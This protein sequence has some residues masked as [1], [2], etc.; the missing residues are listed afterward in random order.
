[1]SVD[2]VTLCAM[3][4]ELP[5]ALRFL[6]GN[7]CGVV[8]RSQALRTGLTTDMIKFRLRSGRW[9]LMHRGVYITF[10]GVPG[11]GARL[12]A[13][14][15]SAGPGAMLS[16][17][18]AAELQELADKATNPIHVTVPHERHV[19]A[20]EGIS[21]H[22]SGRAAEA[23]EQRSY[24]PRTRV[25]ETV[26]DLTQTAKTF[27]DVCGRVTRPLARALTDVA[28]LTPSMTARATLRWRADPYG[29]IAAAAGGDHSVLEL[30]YDRDV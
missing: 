4:S 24:P 13:A 11:R 22:R 18:T 5:S 30:R 8:S 23:M 10:T 12:W 20:F 14:V 27:D 17:Q 9:R 3:K 2:A 21:L 28:R 25:E 19:L 16:H 6:A 29:L 7:Q 1:M 26:L 15:L